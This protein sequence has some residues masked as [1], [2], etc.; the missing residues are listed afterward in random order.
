[1]GSHFV[2]SLE[3]Q[4]SSKVTFS[5]L[6]LKKFRVFVYSAFIFSAASPSILP[7]HRDPSPQPGHE[8]AD[9]NPLTKWFSADVLKQAT[10]RAPSVHEARRKMLSVEELERQ[11]AAVP[12]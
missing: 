8:Q 2:V 4:E 5:W 1:M 6:Q 10:P 9:T 11:Q 7:Q 3:A 12:N